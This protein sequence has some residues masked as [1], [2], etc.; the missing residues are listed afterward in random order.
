VSAKASCAPPSPRPGLRAPPRVRAERERERDEEG[1][2]EGGRGTAIWSAG[3]TCGVACISLYAL[4][5]R[6]RARAAAARQGSCGRARDVTLLK[7]V[8]CLCCYILRSVR[9][10]SK[11]KK[12]QGLLMGPAR[13]L[14]YVLL[15]ARILAA[16]RASVQAHESAKEELCLNFNLLKSG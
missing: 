6:D 16:H 12:Y 1:R 5:T 13:A 10:I 11:R 4:A 3:G 8:W 15:L 2:G 9:A 14:S 7:T